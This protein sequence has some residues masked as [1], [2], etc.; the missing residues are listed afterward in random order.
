MGRTSA[1]VCWRFDFI[2][3]LPHPQSIHNPWGDIFLR[4]MLESVASIEKRQ[5][6]VIG[7]LVAIACRIYYLRSIH[8]GSSLD[9]WMMMILRSMF[10]VGVPPGPFRT[11]RAAINSMTQAESILREG[12]RKACPLCFASRC[13]IRHALIGVSLSL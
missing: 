12:F 9:P 2:M 1:G 10:P 13:Y 8:V 11:W 3:L 4:T 7:L 5:I 6:C